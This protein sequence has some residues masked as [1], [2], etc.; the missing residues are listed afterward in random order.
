MADHSSLEEALAA[1]P[2]QEF[3]R[4]VNVRVKKDRVSACATCWNL[5]TQLHEVASRECGSVEVCP[6]CHK[7]CRFCRVY[8]G[9]PT[10][11]EHADCASEHYARIKK[12]KRKKRRLSWVDSVSSDCASI[13]RHDHLSP[14]AQREEGGS[15]DTETQ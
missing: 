3:I 7:F 14:R 8:Y 10:T 1:L 13:C 12:H 6:D 9:P 5:T 2:L 4:I 11:H 15:G